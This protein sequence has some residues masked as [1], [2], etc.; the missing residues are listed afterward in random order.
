MK[1]VKIDKKDSET[2]PCY[3]THRTSEFGRSTIFVECPFCGRKNVA[4]MW[5][6]CGGGKRCGNRDCRAHLCLG[7]A[8]RDYVPASEGC[9]MAW[10]Q[11]NGGERH[12]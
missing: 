10:E 5:S 12:E 7:G 4:Y 1:L 2:R 6:F 8:Y 11:L 3:Y 9:K